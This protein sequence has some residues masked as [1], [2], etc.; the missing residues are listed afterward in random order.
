MNQKT[1]P[2]YLFAIAFFLVA[3]FASMVAVAKNDNAGSDNAKNDNA[4]TE[5]TAQAET[6]KVDLKESKKP[7]TSDSKTNAQ[8]YKEKNSEVV[9]GIKE[10]KVKENNATQKGSPVNETEEAEGSVEDDS[11]TD[12]TVAET[13]ADKKS[14]EAK[15]RAKKRIQEI[16][17]EQIVEQQPV[18]E[19]I[20]EVE[21]E[22]AVKKFFLGPDYKNLGQ[23]RSSL[24]HNENQIRKLTQAM[25]TLTQ[26]GGDASE[27]ADEMEALVA[28]RKIM[29]GLISE[30]QEQFSLLGWIFKFMNGYE[31][32]PAEE[33]DEELID[34]AQEA[35]DNAQGDETETATDPNPTDTTTETTAS[36]ETTGTDAATSTETETASGTDTTSSDTTA[37]GENETTSDTATGT[38]TIPTVTQ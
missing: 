33:G 2:A 21:E 32:E 4:K 1:L 15:D 36:E 9:K 34:D 20:T 3:G 29:Q 5:K 19:A 13:E 8:A 10:A 27:F 12:E 18:T 35:I 38:D 11:A 26:N 30:N 24:V 7:E 37:T 23:L 28:Q 31:K 17:T 14:T 22:G 25:N 6:K 16:A